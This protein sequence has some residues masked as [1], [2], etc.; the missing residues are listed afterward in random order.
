MLRYMPLGQL[1]YACV[2]RDSCLVMFRS[3]DSF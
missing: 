2:P 1:D 3:R